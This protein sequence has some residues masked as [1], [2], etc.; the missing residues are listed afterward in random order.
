MADKPIMI[1]S[2]NNYYQILV[3]WC[4]NMTLPKEM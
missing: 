4:L 1:V 2:E 3:M